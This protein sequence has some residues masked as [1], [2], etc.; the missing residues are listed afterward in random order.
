MDKSKIK[1]TYKAYKEL[2]KGKSDR[3]LMENIALNLKRLELT[4]EDLQEST[5]KQVVQFK[6]RPN[7]LNSIKFDNNKVN[8]YN[9]ENREKEWDKSSE[10]F[11]RT[12]EEISKDNDFF[13][14]SDDSLREKWVKK[15]YP[16]QKNS[17]DLVKRAT[18]LYKS[19]VRVFSP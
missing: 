14:L 10:E 5:P 15:N 3:Q 6:E 8:Y 4:I 11:E 12:A 9:D 13:V 7:V 17:K 16:E 1:E 19:R 2:I 18:E